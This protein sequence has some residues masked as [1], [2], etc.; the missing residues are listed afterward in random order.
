M[1][2]LQAKV[3]LS[4][5]MRLADWKI[6]AK[7]MKVAHSNHRPKTYSSMKS[8][9]GVAQG[10]GKG[11]IEGN[12]NTD[13]ASPQLRMIMERL[14]KENDQL[15]DQL[16]RLTKKNATLKEESDLLMD[17]MAEGRNAN[18][19]LE[20]EILQL[21]QFS[22]DAQIKKKME[23]EIY[24]LKSEKAD[25][26][27][28][29][30]E[31]KEKI[32]IGD[33]Q[34]QFYQSALVKLKAATSK[35][36]SPISTRHS[37][38]NMSQRLLS[39]K[40]EC[41]KRQSK[42][43]KSIDEYRER[44][45]RL[46]SERDELKDKL[47]EISIEGNLHESSTRNRENI[48]SEDYNEM[49]DKLAYLTTKLAL[50]EKTIK[51]Q[52]EAL[53]SK[54]KVVEGTKIEMKPGKEDKS[55]EFSMESNDSG[56][57]SLDQDYM[58]TMKSSFV[59][60]SNASKHQVHSISEKQKTIDAV[61][62]ML[63]N[64]ESRPDFDEC[65]RYMFFSSASSKASPLV[66]DIL[67]A[68]NRLIKTGIRSCKSCLVVNNSAEDVGDIYKFSDPGP[69]NLIRD[70]IICFHLIAGIR[71]IGPEIPNDL[72]V[73]FISNLA[74]SRLLLDGMVGNAAMLNIDAN[75]DEGTKWTWYV[76]M[77]EALTE[78]GAKCIQLSPASTDRLAII[79]GILTS[80]QKTS[81]NR[82]PGS[83]RR[84]T[85]EDGVD[86][87]T[88]VPRF[89]SDCVNLCI[90]EHGSGGIQFIFGGIDIGSCLTLYSKAV[91]G[92]S[93]G[94]GVAAEEV[95]YLAISA[96]PKQFF[97]FCDKILM[98]MKMPS[99]EITDKTAVVESEKL[100]LLHVKEVSI[101]CLM[102]HA[103]AQKIQKKVKAKYLTQCSEEK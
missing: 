99:G 64:S 5:K 61:L 90:Q 56:Q 17:I 33:E 22:A 82:V 71:S 84:K 69:P 30:T 10:F 39:M 37:T 49:K 88:N 50:A 101:R 16:V 27:I 4:R 89:V 59:N 32:R 42:Y 92:Q 103:A 36:V 51:E 67:N 96:S 12:S 18:N 81:K 23:A 29:N 58:G 76:T 79:F 52:H 40:S 98:E 54:A 6:H 97:Q 86:D 87:G 38:I 47:E 25:L 53:V 45:E 60:F 73:D 77:R 15:K 48:T 26:E 55:F 62:K 85:L 34:I 28:K 102:E 95:L 8:V 9:S 1:A 80:P 21:E 66:Y 94:G 75:I 63:K 46:R 100:L 70:A 43:N 31:L 74:L 3:L 14:Q 35:S 91:S 13:G 2:S 19:R 24:S 78:M 7:D 44:N 57:Q 11:G 65:M 68:I 72:K 83:P 41:A 20:K 93:L